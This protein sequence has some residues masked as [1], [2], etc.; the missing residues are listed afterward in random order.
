MS[1]KTPKLKVTGKR[2]VAVRRMTQAEWSRE[3]WYSDDFGSRNHLVI[4]LEDGTLV[5]PAGW[6]GE[7]P[8]SLIVSDGKH[9]GR[10]VLP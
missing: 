2:I 3:G 6:D 1:A 10:K 5:I 4:E 7:E 9:K 8:G